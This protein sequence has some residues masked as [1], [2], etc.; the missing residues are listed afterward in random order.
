M[1]AELAHGDDEIVAWRGGQSADDLA[2]RACPA[3]EKPDC[4][5]DRLVGG[6]AHGAQRPF[7]RPDPPKIGK[8]H[9]ERNPPLIAAERCHD[10]LWRPGCFGCGAEL[11]A[12][13]FEMDV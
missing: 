11:G 2:G 9:E 5:I 8:S 4:L 12:S 3:E 13:L 7:R 1:V 10:L 6:D